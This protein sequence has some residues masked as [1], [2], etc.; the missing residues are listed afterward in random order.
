MEKLDQKICLD[1]DVVISILKG[2]DRFHYLLD[3]AL[4]H[5]VFVSVVTLFELFLRDTN[6]KD[7]EEFRKRVE[8]LGF[9][10]PASRKASA[11]YKSLKKKG[12]LVGTSDIFIAAICVENNCKLATFNKKDFENINDLKLIS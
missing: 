3:K 9:D 10:E 12:M 8:I 5:E 11:I 4:G 6:L 2:D 7:I 1:T